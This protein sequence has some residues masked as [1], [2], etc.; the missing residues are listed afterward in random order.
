MDSS[1][2]EHLLYVVI[3]QLQQHHYVR[4]YI[5]NRDLDISCNEKKIISLFGA[6]QTL[7]ERRRR[8]QNKGGVMKAVTLKV[9][10]SVARLNDRNGRMRP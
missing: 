9:D 1:S 10:P 8:A 4:T 7:E 2:P 6:T 3:L 5:N